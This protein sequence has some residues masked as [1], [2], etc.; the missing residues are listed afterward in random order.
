MILEIDVGV[1]LTNLLPES[2]Q[3]IVGVFN[4]RMREAAPQL[5]I[6]AEE[7]LQNHFPEKAGFFRPDA[8]IVWVDAAGV[9]VGL[10][11]RRLHF[12]H[13]TPG[14]HRLPYGKRR[15]SDLRQTTGRQRSYNEQLRDTRAENIQYRRQESD[16]AR[17][18]Y[19]P[20]LWLA[21]NIESF[22]DAVSLGLEE[23]L[24]D[25]FSA[26]RP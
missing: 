26:D 16:D 20:G 8:V 9:H 5:R 12:P 15:L 14:F 10:D 3:T 7:W 17:W 21:H 18:H 19:K 11:T 23:C 4:E 1:E 2:E 13:D 22:Q 24:H 25:V 6:A